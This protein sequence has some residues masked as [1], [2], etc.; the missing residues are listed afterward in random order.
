VLVD[1]GLTTAVAHDRRT[2]AALGGDARSTGHAVPDGASWGAFPAHLGLLP[3]RGTAGQ[4]AVAG[5]VD[6]AAAE[7]VPG[8]ERGL[9]VT[10]L[11]YT[12]PLD[13]R[14]VAVTGVTR[15]GVWLIEDG[16]VTSPVANLRFTQAY[17]EAL[18]PGAVKGV[19]A[20]ASVLPAELIVVA[21]C[22]VDA[23]ALHLAEWHFTGGASG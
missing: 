17:P 5:L 23:P 8:V 4:S 14:T 18:A 16:K 1:A 22:W 2:A 15:N 21:S 7:L 13:P 20:A 11:Y 19:G 10:D 3:G 12:R 9:L 6:P